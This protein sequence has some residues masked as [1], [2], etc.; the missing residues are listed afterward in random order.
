MNDF[1]EMREHITTEPLCRTTLRVCVP[2]CMSC[3]T[4][5]VYSNL[6]SGSTR[7]HGIRQI[8]VVSKMAVPRH[9]SYSS[10]EVVEMMTDSGPGLDD[11]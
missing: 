8:C 3:S 1:A 7:Q 9:T 2:S 11:N 10:K 4:N 6:I 5:Q